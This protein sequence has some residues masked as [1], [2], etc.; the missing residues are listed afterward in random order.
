MVKKGVLTMHRRSKA[1]SLAIPRRN[2]G[3]QLYSIINT[4][5][6]ICLLL[7]AWMGLVL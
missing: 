5:G 2:D 4:I 3:P 1:R 7:L 6:V